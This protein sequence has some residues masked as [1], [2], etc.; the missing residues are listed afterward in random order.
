MAGAASR[1]AARETQCN[2]SRGFFGL[3]KAITLSGSKRV[4]DVLK[5]VLEGLDL[6]HPERW[7]E[8]I[9]WQP[10]QHGRGGAQAVREWPHGPHGGRCCASPLGGQYPSTPT[11]GTSISWCSRIPDAQSTIS[12]RSAPAA[13]A[14]IRR[15]RRH[16]VTSKTGCLVLAVYE[17]PVIIFRKRGLK[18]KTAV[19]P[20]GRE[21][22][23]GC[24]G[25][26]IRLSRRA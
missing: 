8:T 7:E 9:P 21:C 2:R 18:G 6:F 19:P 22:A 11:P 20:P 14:F 1:P 25:R 13:C 3:S 26:A 15:D 17:K 23:A 24:I 10:F 5:H 16:S 4:H 12:G